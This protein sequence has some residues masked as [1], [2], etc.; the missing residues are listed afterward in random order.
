MK[1][2][3]QTLNYIQNLLTNQNYSNA[4]CEELIIGVIDEN[5]VFGAVFAIESGVN[6]DGEYSSEMN[7]VNHYIPV[8][9]LT[10]YSEIKIV[11]EVV[12]GLTVA[13]EED[14]KQFITT[15]EMH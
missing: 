10:Q 7:S 9:C 14:Q 1:N 15:K 4:K 6:E 12:R 2:I 3:Y 11:N 8:E 13:L 5:L